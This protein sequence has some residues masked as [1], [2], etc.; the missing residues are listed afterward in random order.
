MRK[1]IETIQENLIE[2]DNEQCD[3]TIPFNENNNE[4]IKY[5]DIPCPQCGENLLTKEDFI[6]SLKID[7]A[8][9]WINKWFSWITIFYS[10]KSKENPQVVSVK[11][12]DGIKIKNESCNQ[13]EEL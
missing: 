6:M 9:N 5:I 3:F 1:L 8:V 2:C 12:H 4:L 11:V 13:K 10:K 7:K